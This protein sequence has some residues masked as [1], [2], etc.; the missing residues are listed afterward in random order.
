MNEMEF[1]RELKKVLTKLVAVDV[2]QSKGIVVMDVSH[3][4]EETSNGWVYHIKA[5]VNVTK[6]KTPS[7]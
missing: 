6:I 1:S 5:N 2:M 4:K 3:E 7:E